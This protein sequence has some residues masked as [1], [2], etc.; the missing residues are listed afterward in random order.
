MSDADDSNPIQEPLD[1]VRLSLD[2]HVFVK[3]RGDRELRG[4]LHAYDSHCN[5]VLGEVEETIYVVND[6]EDDDSVKT[7]K[8]N[9]EMLFVR[10]DSVV[11]ISPQSQS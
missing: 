6:D 3:L 10:G 2:E 11:L 1:L 5:L 4:R 7:I 8:N 9:S